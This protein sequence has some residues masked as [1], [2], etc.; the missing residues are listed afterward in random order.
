[1]R[2]VAY[3]QVAQGWQWNITMFNPLQHSSKQCS[4]GSSC[5]SF[6]ALGGYLSL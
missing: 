2:D 4:V 3:T 6:T 1:M 5:S